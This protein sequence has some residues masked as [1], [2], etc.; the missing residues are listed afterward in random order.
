[1]SCARQNDWVLVQKII[2]E[3]DQRAENLPQD[4][5]S[6]PLVM[7]LKGFLVDDIAEI[8]KNIT[9]KTMTDRITTGIL[10]EVFPNYSHSFGNFVPE[11]ME[12][13]RQLKRVQ[14]ERY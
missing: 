7:W 3:S 8:G 13:G 11:I 10:V 9:I 5:R 2:L 14:A 6:V 4:T 12:I 1:M